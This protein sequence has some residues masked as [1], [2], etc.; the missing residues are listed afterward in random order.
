MI[1]KKKFLYFNRI[2]VAVIGIFILLSCTRFAFSK[3]YTNGKGEAISEIAFYTINPGT[4]TQTLKM[5]DIKPDGKDYVYDINVSNF[6]DNNVSEVDMEYHLSLR[7]TTNIPIEYK[8]Y[9]NGSTMNE[10]N[11]KE[12]IQDE[13]GMYF[14]RFQA[15]VGNFQ[16]NVE[17]TD[18]YQLVVNF[19]SIYNEETYQDLIESVEVTIDA[20]Q[21]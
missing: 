1:D 15:P 6:Q 5:F 19:P 20:K 16:K 2:T 18:H 13:D 14:F 3:F 8:I 11:Q 7:T 10:F 21:L 17:K 9:L 12:V 4:Q